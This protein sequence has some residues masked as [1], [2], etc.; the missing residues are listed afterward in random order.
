MKSPF[1]QTAQILRDKGFNVMPLRKGTKAPF[2]Q[3]WQD[4]CN[5]LLPKEYFESYLKGD[6]NIGV[7]LGKQSNII[8][9]D[10]D[11]NIDGI[12]ERIKKICGTSPVIKKGEKGC[13]MF[14]KFNGEKGAKYSV[15]GEMVFEIL[16]TGNQTVLPPSI[17]P[18][19]KKPYTYTGK[20]TLEEVNNLPYLPLDFKLKVDEIFGKETKA[21]SNAKSSDASRNDIEEALTHISPNGYEVWLNVGMALRS[22]E[23]EDLCELWDNWSQT[24]NTYEGSDKI[25]KKWESFSTDGGITIATIFKLAIDNG[26]KNK[27]DDRISNNISFSSSTPDNGL[28]TVSKAKEQ[29]EQW[30]KYGYPTGKYV[31]IKELEGQGQNVR[32]HLRKKELTVITGVPNSGKSEFLSYLVYEAAINLKYK[33]LF[34][35]FENN[36]DQ[37]IESFIT[38]K[39]GKRLSKRTEE[40]S[41]QAENFVKDNFFFYDHTRMSTKIEEIVK[42][43]EHVK[44]TK[45]LDIIV[46]DP[47]SYL[48]SE[49]GCSEGNLDHVK[50]CLKELSRC[51][52][53]LDV[54]IFLV[55]HP[56]SRNVPKTL[57]IK[58]HSD[59][60]IDLYSISGGA[61][62][63]NSCDNGIICVRSGLNTKIRITKI[64]DQLVDNTG[65]FVM[66]YNRDTRKFESYAEEFES[67]Y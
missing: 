60:G 52:K 29:I 7:C 37:H 45:G 51:C 40:E 63:Y 16:S 56:K 66:T 9:L 55:A 21:A 22:Y 54:H 46:V 3:K 61:T 36:L 59:H 47:F 50:Q 26:Y 5:T 53:V 15:N 33:T 17:H 1:A 35:A 42:V 48:S 28:Y 4:Y 49:Y 2:I 18:A 67:E 13:T 32:W 57:N 19:T 11:T 20:E 58:D 41:T 8:A 14:F 30:K 23:K 27:R 64:R 62:F 10:F 38:R 25:V 39:S 6:Y 65:E 34:F 12:H 31:G 24:G 44:K 43:C